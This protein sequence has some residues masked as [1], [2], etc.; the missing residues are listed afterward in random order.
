MK[1]LH[2]IFFS[3]LFVFFLTGPSMRAQEKPAPAEKP[4]VDP[5]A[6][7]LVERASRFL[8]GAANVAFSAEVSED[9]QLEDGGP[10]LQA[11]RTLEVRLRRPDRLRIQVR[12]ADPLRAFYF[13]GKTL[14]IHDLA[15]E[16]YAEIKTPATIDETL[17]VAHERYD[18]SI[19]VEDLLISQPFGGGAAKAKG[20]QYLGQ[21]L[22]RGDVCHHVAFQH[23]TIHW[24]AW[25]QDGPEPLVRKAVLRYQEEGGR[26][27]TA[28]I[29]GW[30]LQSA[31]RD[32]VFEF[33][34]PPGVL[35]IEAVPAEAETKETK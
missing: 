11:S 29:S 32:E 21:D 24:E 25:I 15:A 2:P 34:A 7:A 17:D 8:A 9:V 28:I 30:D 5:Y 14:K 19:P 27:L 18:I 33:I 1:F 26:T 13:D 3:C 31:Q 4:A 23:E 12:N 16:T 6:R 20:G 35:K 22:V 10:V